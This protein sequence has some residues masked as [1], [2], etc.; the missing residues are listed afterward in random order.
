[1]TETFDLFEY[2]AYLRQRWR[3]P[4]VACATAVA[5][6][7]AVSLLLPRRYT[8][9]ATLIIEPPAGND[10][11]TATAVSPVY[12]E[13]LRTYE[14]FAGS[15]S[16]F[17][18][19]AERFHLQKGSQ[20]IESL[21]Q[22]VLQVAKLRDTKILE[23]SV[24]LP[25]PKLA[26]SVVDFIAGQAVSMSR[27][28][29][30]AGD[31]DLV[32]DAIQQEEQARQQLERAEK[33]W[34]ENAAREPVEALRASIDADVDLLAKLR[35]DLVE[36]E[37]DAAG[38]RQPDNGSAAEFTRHQRRAAESRVTVLRT[39]T[40]ALA[41]TIEA[42]NATL[43]RR[44]AK[45][46]QLQSEL[47]IARTAYDSAAA[48]LRDVRASVG[49]HGERLRVIDPGIVPERPSSPNIPV[50]VIAAFLVAV[51]ASTV[52]LSL[53]FT[54]RHRTASVAAAGPRGWRA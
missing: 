42:E 45:G 10:V 19:A 30:L 29:N 3:V 2:L 23:I 24:T 1:M 35:Q 32:E 50:N 51:I 40:D 54:W 37:A 22:R 49:M 43:A 52:Y 34:G 39:R 25:Q 16:L 8:A 12:L 33:A 27:G 17:Q 7:L 26:Q 15:D 46:E 53:T 28:E 47:R 41:K 38:Y 48:R 14:R 36:A 21:K 5:I 11:R 44:V 9:T 20:T 6:A 4:L 13:S 31:R 18:Q